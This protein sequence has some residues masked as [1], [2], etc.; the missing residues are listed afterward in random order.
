MPVASFGTKVFSASQNK[1]FTFDDFSRTSSLNI[2][3]QEIDGQKPSTYI[4]GSNL[5]DVV[6]T[7][8]LFKQKELDVR[9]EIDE[10]ITIKNQAVPQTLIIGNKPMGQN[11]FLLT[12]VAIKESVI[13]GNGNFLRTKV[14]LQFKEFIRYGQKQET[15]NSTPSTTKTSKETKKRAN[16]NADNAKL[17]QFEKQLFNSPN[18]SSPK[19]FR[20]GRPT[21]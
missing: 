4:K 2:E 10:W 11:K 20:G 1:I 7:L 3:E 18:N 21:E 16:P 9:K 13:D 15:T 6:L 12:S 5:D 17:D 19:W 8:P 14:E